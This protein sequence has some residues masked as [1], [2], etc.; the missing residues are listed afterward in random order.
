[1]T[2]V[3][4]ATHFRTQEMRIQINKYDE[5]G[6]DI[7]MVRTEYPADKET[8]KAIIR[9]HFRAYRKSKRVRINFSI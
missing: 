8:A 9:T 6:E 7:G 5:N 4:T 1:M 3:I 2:V